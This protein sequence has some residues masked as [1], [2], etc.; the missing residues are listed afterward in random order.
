MK[1]L[2]KHILV[3]SLA[4]IAL[5]Y[6]FAGILAYKKFRD[7]FVWAQFSNQQK[8]ARIVNQSL[9]LYFDKL[10]LAAENTVL[11]PAFRPEANTNDDR[12]RYER[13]S[14]KVSKRFLAD[15]GI[16]TIL[17]GP[18]KA[19]E[20]P[21]G[22]LKLFNWQIYKALP[23]KNSKGDL[24]A[25]GRRMLARNILRTFKDIHYVF[26]MDANGDL[27]FLEPFDIQK[28]IT[29]FNYEFRDYLQL[30]KTSR[31]TAISEGYISHD[32]NR[33]QI[34]TVATP[35]FDGTNKIV[36]IFA[37]SVSAN[38]LRE[39]VFK[40]LKESMDVR[41]GTVFYLVDRHGHVVASSSGK[42]IYFPMEGGKDDEVDQG[43][44]RNI[45]F[46]K[47]IEWLADT[48]EKGNLWERG[49]K[50][51]R[52][53]SLRQDFFGEYKNLDGTE[54]FGSFYP[55]APISYGTLNWGILIETPKN[56]L[57]ASGRSLIQVFTVAGLALLAIIFVLYA[58]IFRSFNR[59]ESRL[60]TKE[61]EI[62][63]I[64]AQ[65]AHDIRSPLAA[66]DSVMG[67]V[68]KLPE[69][70][71]L[72]IHGA[73]NRIRDI[74]N[75]LLEKHRSRDG[76]VNRR[77]KKLPNDPS[78]QKTEI[79]L[80][81]SL[82]ESLLT[83]KRSEFGNRP[84]IEIEFRRNVSSYGL[85]A[86]IEPTEFKRVLSNLINNSVQ[87][88]GD[89]GLI[90]VTA[91]YDRGSIQLE[92]QDDGPGIPPDIL[93]KLGQK[94]ITHGKTGGAGLGLYHA[95]TMAEA[96]GGNL[97]ITSEVGKGTTVTLI[98]PSA[99]PPQWFMRRLWLDPRSPVVI[100]DDDLTIHQAWQGRLDSSD[101]KDNNLEIHHFSTPAELRG[102]VKENPKASR[103]AVYLMDYELLGFKETG[104]TLIEELGLGQQAILVTSRFEEK[105]ILDN[106]RRLGV[107]LIPKN[108]VGFVVIKIETNGDDKTSSTSST[109]I[110]DTILIDDDLLVHRMWQRAAK[111]HGQNLKTFKSPQEFFNAGGEL[112]PKE[113]AIYL[114]SVLGDDIK[115]E[116]FAQELHAKGFTNLYLATGHSPD[117]FKDISCLKAIVGK[118]P[119]WNN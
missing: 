8:M 118:E 116:D 97:K 100:L 33:T 51:W 20:P 19:I 76:Q 50:S 89:K 3:S 22:S 74:A 82:I 107:R 55:A 52:F 112:F 87:A 109:L 12:I 48:L 18:R 66:L 79:L 32:Q 5:I 6:L 53:N 34:I 88:I 83:E 114:D 60:D 1:Y 71:R 26:E 78:A 84:D 96:W 30:A 75:N 77:Q 25:S 24:I 31:A 93:A 119:P 17:V 47:E 10:R 91:F 86:K 27:V 94:G 56:Q 37:V 92:V 73:V 63:L 68:S 42:N 108:L 81:S 15:Q 9:N 29:S 110:C 115:G 13:S 69:E 111:S 16:L 102:W 103:K 36:K 90:F 105:E 85:F 38:T 28:N 35:I 7:D 58:V 4:L 99:E 80:L 21:A 23:E 101:A 117:K 2:P 49:T 14:S 95:K 11:Q 61:K 64:S 57:L 45:G 41:D 40:S 104:L 106:C 70:E 44:L 67:N 98:F 54:V 39:K 46:F 62:G 72:I 113:T 59:I 43:N 65:V